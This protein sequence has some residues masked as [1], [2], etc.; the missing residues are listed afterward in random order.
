LILAFLC[1]KEHTIYTDTQYPIYGVQN[2]T[3]KKNIYLCVSTTVSSIIAADRH[4]FHTLLFPH[5]I[6][7]GGDV[8]TLK[9]ARGTGVQI[10]GHDRGRELGRRLRV[11]VPGD[12]ALLIATIRQLVLVGGLLA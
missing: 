1:Y 9:V 11:G 6:S 2:K 5:D 7:V 8:V 4:S 12:K 10:R 3:H